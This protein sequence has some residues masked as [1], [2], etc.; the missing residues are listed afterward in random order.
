MARGAR[1]RLLAEIGEIS[2]LARE[3][4]AAAVG[5]RGPEVRKAMTAA[6]RER[7]AK[8]W[9]SVCEVASARRQQMT[10]RDAEMIERR[11]RLLLTPTDTQA[12]AQVT[13]QVE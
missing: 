9:A 11:I 12:N 4:A 1:A 6:K 7:E 8:R 5:L 2:E 13:V 3:M 10:L